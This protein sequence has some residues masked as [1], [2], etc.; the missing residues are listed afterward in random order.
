M[1]G[2]LGLD[3]DVDGAVDV[4]ATFVVDYHGCTPE[5]RDRVDVRDNASGAHVH[6][7]VDAYAVAR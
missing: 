7:Y 1:N 4:S 3:S 2:P 6:G 5:E